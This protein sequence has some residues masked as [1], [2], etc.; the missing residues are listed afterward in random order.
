M[1]D[2]TRIYNQE[3]KPYILRAYKSQIKEVEAKEKKSKSLKNKLIDLVSIP[4][5][6]NDN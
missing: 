5:I 4:I 3:I 2:A 6:Q 1:N